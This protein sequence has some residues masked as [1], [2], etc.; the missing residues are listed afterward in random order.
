M[1]TNR[2]RRRISPQQE[3]ILYRLLNG[4]TLM[5]TYLADGYHA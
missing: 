1:T 3:A 5:A 2:T 4:K